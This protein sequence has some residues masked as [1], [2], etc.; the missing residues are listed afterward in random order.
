ML[1]TA[2]ILRRYTGHIVHRI[3]PDLPL[4][5]RRDS[6]LIHPSIL[7]PNQRMQYITG[8]S[9]W[10]ASP[11]RHLPGPAYVLLSKAYPGILPSKLESQG[12]P[13]QVHSASHS[14]RLDRHKCKALPNL[15]PL[16]VRAPHPGAWLQAPW[17]GEHY[18]RNLPFFLLDFWR[19]PW[20]DDLDPLGVLWAS[21]PAALV[22]VLDM[23]PFLM[24]RRSGGWWSPP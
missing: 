20:Y 8:L 15:W 14:F 16:L 1:H 10:C 5:R 23:G 11:A 17:A 21:Y 6:F 22:G 12:L 13:P 9:C 18:F 24:P 7:P 19:G 2:H 4:L 3:L